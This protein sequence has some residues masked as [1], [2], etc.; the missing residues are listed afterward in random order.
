MYLFL[1]AITLNE[2][3]TYYSVPIWF[4]QENISL[5]KMLTT[6]S[7][8][9][10]NDYP[11]N[12]IRVYKSFNFQYDDYPNDYVSFNFLRYRLFSQK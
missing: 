4:Q 5:L 1:E 10:C 9:Q 2:R 3:D 7:S 11:N 12:Y 6:S 8:F